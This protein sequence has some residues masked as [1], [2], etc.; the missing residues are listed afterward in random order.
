MGWCGLHATC[1]K[2]GTVDRRAE[3]DRH[4]MGGLNRG[5]YNVLKSAMVGSTY[6]AAVQTLKNYSGKDHKGNEIYE[7]IPDNKRETFG[8]ICLTMVN[9][10]DY[11][12]FRYKVISEDMGPFESKC[13]DSILKLL[14]PTE[15]ELAFAWRKRCKENNELK[16]RLTRR[17]PIKFK[18]THEMTSGHK[19]GDIIELHWCEWGKRG[20]YTDGHYRYPSRLFTPDNIEF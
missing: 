14:S 2:N 16:R 17:E 5:H 20:F 15:D 7:D 9:M 18:V 13:P 1:Y 19:P 11:F 4:F 6:Y 10:K 8:V 12:N 3:C